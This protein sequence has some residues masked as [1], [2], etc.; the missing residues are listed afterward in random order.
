[1]TY[2][3][4]ALAGH[5]RVAFLVCLAAAFSSG[6]AQD[7]KPSGWVVIPITEYSGLRAKA[8][9]VAHASEPPAVQAGVSRID[10]D[11]KVD[12]DLA[13][14]RAALTVDVSGEGWVRVPIPAAL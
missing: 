2:R 14:G 4:S 3:I 7:T 1:M 6:Q 13:I 5:R 9:P 12:G 8:F 11:L 10:Y